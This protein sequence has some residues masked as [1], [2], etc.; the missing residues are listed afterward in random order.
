MLEVDGEPRDVSIDGSV[1]AVGVRGEK[2]RLGRAESI[3]RKDS[4]LLDDGW[5]KERDKSE[6]QDRDE[7]EGQLSSQRKSRDASG[8]RNEREG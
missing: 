3:F 8:K 4:G 5:L 2:E 7:I 6:R 1:G